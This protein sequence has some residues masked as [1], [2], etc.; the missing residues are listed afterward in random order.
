MGKEILALYFNPVLYFTFL[1]SIGHLHFWICS[2]L[3]R[4][5]MQLLVKIGFNYF[6]SMFR[7]KIVSLYF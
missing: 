4:G 7:C 2:T 1:K 3:K 6:L 5:A